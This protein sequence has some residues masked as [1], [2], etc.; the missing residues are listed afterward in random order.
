[1]SAHDFIVYFETILQVE[2]TYPIIC[3]R[4]YKSK[5]TLDPSMCTKQI[6]ESLHNHFTKYTSVFDVHAAVHRDTFLIIE[7]IRCTNF[8]K[9]FILE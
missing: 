5:I 4:K 9:Y 7:P 2:S 1:M 3:R 6:T 8:S